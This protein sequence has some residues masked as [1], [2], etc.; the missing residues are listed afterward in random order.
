MKG[1]EYGRKEAGGVD[2]RYVC[3]TC[4]SE[5]KDKS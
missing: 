1:G 5:I 2:K 4:M 3:E